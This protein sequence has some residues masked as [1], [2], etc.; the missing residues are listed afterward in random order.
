MLVVQCLFGDPGF[1]VFSGGV[2]QA[3]GNAVQG[4][5]DAALEELT[6]GIVLAHPS[7]SA[8]EANL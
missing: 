3:L 7:H 5:V 8:K 1:V 2:F 4:G 6:L